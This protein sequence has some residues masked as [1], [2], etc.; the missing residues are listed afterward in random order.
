LSELIGVI[1]RIVQ[2]TIN[3][4]NMADKATGTVESVSPLRV[5]IDSSIQSIPSAALLLTDTVKERIVPVQGGEGRV[6]IREGL[7]EGDRVLMLK[8]Q[9]GQQY[10]ILS[11]IT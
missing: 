1:Q 6:T 2:N 5:K 4:M 10:I 7:K 3:S 11:R 8:V 9:N